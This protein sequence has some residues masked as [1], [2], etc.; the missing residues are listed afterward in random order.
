L[1]LNGGIKDLVAVAV[2]TRPRQ[3]NWPIALEPGDNALELL[4]EFGTPVARE[5]KWPGQ[6][7]VRRSRSNGASL[8]ASMP[9][10]ND[11]SSLL[12]VGRRQS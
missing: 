4:Q 10:T 3:P 9:I 1:A 5:A 2:A 7:S 11:T 12:R 6:A 8:A